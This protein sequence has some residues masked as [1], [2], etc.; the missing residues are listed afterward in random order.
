MGKTK[1]MVMGDMKTLA[2][3]PT[4]TPNLSH[5][6]YSRRKV[7]YEVMPHLVGKTCTGMNRQPHVEADSIIHVSHPFIPS[8]TVCVMITSRRDPGAAAEA[9]AIR[10]SK[11]N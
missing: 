11:A 8:C 10:S 2:A 6:N 1:T 3:L 5:W 7:K 4:L 9:D